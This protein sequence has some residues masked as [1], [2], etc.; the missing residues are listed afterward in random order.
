MIFDPFIGSGSTAL[1][2]I[3]A[4]RRFFGIDLEDKYVE[5]ANDRVEKLKMEIEGKI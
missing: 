4:G 2:A 1:A 3:E 5:L